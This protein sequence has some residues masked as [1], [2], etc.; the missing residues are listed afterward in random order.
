MDI[1]TLSYTQFINDPERYVEFKGADQSYSLSCGYPIYWMYDKS[2]P[3]N[4]LNI[5]NWTDNKFRINLNDIDGL[6]VTFKL[7]V[8]WS[9]CASRWSWG[10]CCECGQWL[11]KTI[12]VTY[13]KFDCATDALLSTQAFGNFEVS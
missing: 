6:K 11:D 2:D 1:T 9:E 8:L 7:M 4:L 3:Y 13:K 12:T 10:S 5:P